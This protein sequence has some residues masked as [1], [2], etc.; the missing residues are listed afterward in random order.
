MQ[1]MFLQLMDNVPP[2]ELGKLVQRQND[3]TVNQIRR[4][5]GLNYPQMIQKQRTPLQGLE[6]KY[7][8]TGRM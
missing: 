8:I 5:K 2:E 6:G 4:D 3:L 1:N 7:A